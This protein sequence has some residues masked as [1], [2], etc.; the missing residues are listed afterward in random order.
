[1]SGNSEVRIFD[2]QEPLPSKRLT[3]QQATL[4][5]FERRFKRV[6]NQLRLLMHIGDLQKWS[7][8]HHGGHTKICNYVG[9][10][11]PLAIFYGDVGTGKT[12]TAECTANRLVVEDEKA[13]DS[14]LFKMSTRVRGS[15]KVGEMGTLINHAFQEVVKSAGG[16]RRAILIIDEGDSLAAKRSQEHSHHEDKVAVNTLIQNIDELA[17]FNGRIIL[18]LCT[19]RHSAL[20]PAILRR[21]A[22]KEEFL[23]PTDDERL[24][25]FNFDLDDFGFSKKELSE[26]VEATAFSKKRHANWT[27]SDIRLRLYPAAL[28]LAFPDKK[29]EMRHLLDSAREIEPSPVMEDV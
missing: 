16:K 14:V 15:G 28:A 17:R 1:M 9:A 5:G 2:N 22:V 3:E 21:A 25:L 23:R 6:S 27:Y 8:K 7:Q 11:Y 26:L 4:L 13:D 24:D 18:F 12:V 20:D 10:Q 19:N 29:L